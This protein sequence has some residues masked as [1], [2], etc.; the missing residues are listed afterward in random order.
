MIRHP[1]VR[2]GGVLGVREDKGELA[3]PVVMKNVRLSAEEVKPAV[4]CS[5]N[6]DR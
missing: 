2:I 5:L 3:K 6:V 1:A 4:S